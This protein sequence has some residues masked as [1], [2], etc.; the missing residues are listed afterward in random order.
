MASPGFA[1]KSEFV[2][3]ALWASVGPIEFFK[4]TRA[5]LKETQGSSK[6]AR[7]SP[8]KTSSVHSSTAGGPIVRNGLHGQ[9]VIRPLLKGFGFHV[10]N[11]VEL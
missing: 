9:R 10:S 11:P 8:T 2:R 4:E 1:S 7:R 6:A 3:H 5:I